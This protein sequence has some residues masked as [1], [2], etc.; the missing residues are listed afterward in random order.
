[1]SIVDYFVRI[2]RKPAD[3]DSGLPVYR[4]WWFAIPLALCLI[5]TFYEIWILAEFWRHLTSDARFWLVFL[6]VI[7]AFALIVAHSQYRAVR[8]AGAE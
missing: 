6:A 1:M 8:D 5:D 4:S 2:G 3:S 7:T